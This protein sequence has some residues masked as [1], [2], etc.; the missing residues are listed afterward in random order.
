VD[1]PRPIPTTYL[2][3]IGNPA[4]RFA[5]LAIRVY[6]S[7]GTA[8][9]NIYV[10][11]SAVCP[12]LAMHGNV[13][14]FAGTKAASESVSLRQF[15]DCSVLVISHDFRG[16][17]ARTL[18]RF[19]PPAR[20][21]RSLDLPLSEVC[22]HVPLRYSIVYHKENVKMNTG[23]YHGI[24]EIIGGSPF[25]VLGRKVD[26]KRKWYRWRKYAK[27]PCFDSRFLFSSLA[28]PPMK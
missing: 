17:V 2:A 9:A 10:H 15:F 7:L 20:S 26:R 1:L 25:G 5:E 19:S 16:L 8:A 21:S 3:S 6:S 11:H 13:S 22:F 23:K 4:T 14:A 28:F 18:M 12:W 24:G 27:S